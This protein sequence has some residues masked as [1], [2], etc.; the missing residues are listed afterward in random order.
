MTSKEFEKV[1]LAT[2]N[3]Q[4]ALVSLGEFVE[5]S[6]TDKIDS[7]QQALRKAMVALKEVTGV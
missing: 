3:V 2:I 6:G 1:G 4:S 7:A 5:G